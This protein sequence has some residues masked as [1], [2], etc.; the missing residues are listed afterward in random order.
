MSDRKSKESVL[1][2]TSPSS[3]SPGHKNKSQYTL[4]FGLIWWSWPEAEE[5]LDNDSMSRIAIAIAIS[6]Q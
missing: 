6:T 5:G 2:M 3:T 4:G 1:K